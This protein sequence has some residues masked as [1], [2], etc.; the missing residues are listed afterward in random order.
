MGSGPSQE[1]RFERLLDMY[2]RTC[3][4]LQDIIDDECRNIQEIRRTARQMLR[5]GA[6]QVA[7]SKYQQVEHLDA[8]V[9][10]IARVQTDLMLQKSTMQQ[11]KALGAMDEVF[12]IAGDLLVSMDKRLPRDEMMLKAK[13]FRDGVSKALKRHEIRVGAQAEADKEVRKANRKRA[14]AT[15]VDT[16]DAAIDDVPRWKQMM[17]QDYEA[18]F[19]RVPS[20]LRLEAPAERLASASASAL[21]PD[22]VTKR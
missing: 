22:L 11:M 2:R 9:A 20:P 8:L 18:Q 16:E 1:E 21:A 3:D 5:S 13:A 6:T 12:V 19:P 4:E 10:D 17:E 14:Q 7:A 15:G